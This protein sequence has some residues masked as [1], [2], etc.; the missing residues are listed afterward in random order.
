MREI[1]YG[2]G[3]WVNPDNDKT[4]GPVDFAAHK[5]EPVHIGGCKGCRTKIVELLKMVYPKRT[6][7]LPLEQKRFDF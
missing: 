5:L 4:C 1:V 6:I 3:G 7:D 2:T